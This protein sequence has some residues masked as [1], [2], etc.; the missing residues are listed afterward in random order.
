MGNDCKIFTQEEE[1]KLLASLEVNKA[2]LIV[3]LD[4]IELIYLQAAYGVVKPAAM[5]TLMKES[6]PIS[7]EK[8][9]I[10]TNAWITHAKGIVECLRHKSIFPVQVRKVD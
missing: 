4:T 7:E 3:L 1:E 5:E 8:V 6:F 2:T 10:F 9:S